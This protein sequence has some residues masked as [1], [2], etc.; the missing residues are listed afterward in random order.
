MTNVIKWES[1]NNIWEE[2]KDNKI[3]VN[4]IQNDTRQDVW[5]IL[6]EGE[7]MILEYECKVIYEEYCVFAWDH[8]LWLFITDN[9]VFIFIADKVMIRLNDDLYDDEIDEQCKNL[10]K[11]IDVLNNLNTIVNTW[12][13]ETMQ[14]ESYFE[15]YYS[16]NGS[17]NLIKEAQKMFTKL[18]DKQRFMNLRLKALEKVE[19][20]NKLV[21]KMNEAFDYYTWIEIEMSNPNYQKFLLQVKE[22]KIITENMQLRFTKIVEAIEKILNIHWIKY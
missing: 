16:C 7:E 4:N 3:T 13:A 19:F 17:I 21:E 15:S 9:Y 1:V 11:I 10:S 12:T 5:E 20:F 2:S 6:N 14:D 18:K 22:I 8:I